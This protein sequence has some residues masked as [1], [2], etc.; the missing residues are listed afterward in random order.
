M[1]A[2]EL[3]W[4]ASLRSPLVEGLVFNWDVK[5]PPV[6]LLPPALPGSIGGGGGPGGGGGAA[7]FYGTVLCIFGV[8]A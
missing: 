3:A 1:L 8:T 7:I 4:A 6:A 5:L 2:T